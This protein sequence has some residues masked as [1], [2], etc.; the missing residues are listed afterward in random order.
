MRSKE[1][2]LIS[3]Q[4]DVLFPAT[5]FPSL[6]IQIEMLK[7]RL[8]GREYHASGG[9]KTWGPGQTLIRNP[10]WISN[11]MSSKVWDDITYPF[12]NFKGSTVEFWEWINN[13]THTL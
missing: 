10:V 3:E 4:P 12:P 2:D 6:W 5:Q 8:D 7:E 11:N 9:Y 13:S 1:A